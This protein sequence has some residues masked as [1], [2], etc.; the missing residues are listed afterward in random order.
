MP[1]SRGEKRF[2]PTTRVLLSRRVTVAW[3]RRRV[4]LGVLAASA[5]L[6]L[7]WWTWRHWTWWSAADVPLVPAPTRVPTYELA[8]RR[9]AT[10][11]RLLDDHQTIL[12]TGVVDRNAPKLAPACEL[13]L[14]WGSA[15]ARVPLAASDRGHRCAFLQ[16]SW[17]EDHH[18]HPDTTFAWFL[19]ISPPLRPSW[20]RARHRPDLH[21]FIARAADS[22]PVMLPAPQR[23]RRA[24][25][26]CLP[27]LQ[28][29]ARV[30]RVVEWLQRLRQRHQ[31]EAARMYLVPGYNRTLVQQ[32]SA[33][34]VSD[35]QLAGLTVRFQVVPPGLKLHYFGQYLA[36]YDCWVR[37]ATRSRWTAFI[38]LDEEFAMPLTRFLHRHQ[39]LSRWLQTRQR[40]EPNVAGYT[41]GS[42]PYIKPGLHQEPRRQAPQPACY[43]PRSGWPKSFDTA[44]GIVTVTVEPPELCIGPPGRRKHV[45]RPDRMRQ[46]QIHNAHAREPYRV[47]HLNTTEAF[48]VHYRGYVAG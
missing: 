9:W 22:V 24:L 13:V 1:S 15:D 2:A 28:N 47:V 43:P 25:S 21:L 27:V 37:E 44:A 48:L 19:R 6:L 14:R 18:N 10:A 20:L 34:V 30:E 46:I 45:L 31:L 26:A 7:L 17:E 23:I 4:R 11:A 29:N 36:V 16:E 39:S 8:T 33:A 40:H 42:W 35:P 38:D 3:S 32:V 12:L 41:F 5:L